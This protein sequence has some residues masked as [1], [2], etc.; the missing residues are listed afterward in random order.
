V[1]DPQPDVVAAFHAASAHFVELVAAIDPTSYDDEAT[2]EWSLLELVAHALRAYVAIDETLARPLDPASRRVS[3]A[4]AYFRAGMSMPGIHTGITERARR[5]AAQVRDD[6]LRHARELATHAAGVVD[7]TPGDREVQHFV[8]RMRFDDYLVT[9]LTELVLHGVDIQA[10]MGAEP[11]A[12]A[13]AAAIVRDE[14]LCLVDRV[15]ALAVA[16]VLS[17]RS[18]LMSLDVLG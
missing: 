8:G 13:D 1:A 11:S 3:S 14:L 12:P 17:G 5:G 18:R 9:R 2:S 4:A 10:A 6:P 16:C 15:D 7:S